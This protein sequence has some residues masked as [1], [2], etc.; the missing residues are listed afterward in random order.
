MIQRAD[1]VSVAGHLIGAGG[2]LP[3]EKPGGLVQRAGGDGLGCKPAFALKA[4]GVVAGAPQEAEAGIDGEHGEE[5]RQQLAQG[6]DPAAAGG[7]DAPGDVAQPDKG[8]EQGGEEQHLRHGDVQTA[9]EGAQPTLQ[10]R[11]DGVPEPVHGGAAGTQGKIHGEKR[12]Q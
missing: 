11:E 2:Q 4:V 10:G 5:R 8:G 7:G 1:A 12:R 3:G 6:A 9:A